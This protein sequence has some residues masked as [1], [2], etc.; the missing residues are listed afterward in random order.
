MEEDDLLVLVLVELVLLLL[1]VV[2]LLLLLLLPLR[3][4][5]RT[6]LNMLRKCERCVRRTGHHIRSQL[7]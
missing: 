6:G 4:V 7:L 5:Q 2:V 3:H 1:M